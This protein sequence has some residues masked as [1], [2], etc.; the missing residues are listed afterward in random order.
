VW[1]L[2]SARICISPPVRGIQQR[3][4][5]FCAVVTM[6][7]W[8]IVFLH[9]CAGFIIVVGLW[10]P[11]RAGGG[12]YDYCCYGVRGSECTN[13]LCSRR[14]MPDDF[15]LVPCRLCAVSVK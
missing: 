15:F 8:Y 12:L 6:E 3:W 5:S 7:L 10:V 11:P 14:R 13:R 4:S 2:E 9:G 1:L